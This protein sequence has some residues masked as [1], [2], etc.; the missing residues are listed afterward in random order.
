MQ[1]LRVID[2]HLGAKL[3]HLDTKARTTP[4]LLGLGT[5]TW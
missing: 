2:L 1:T 5:V 4:K 3:I